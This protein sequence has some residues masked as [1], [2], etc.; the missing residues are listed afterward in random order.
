MKPVTIYS[1]EQVSALVTYSVWGMNLII[2]QRPREG[3]CTILLLLFCLNCKVKKT[4]KKK[5]KDINTH[6]IDMVSFADGCTFKRFHPVLYELVYL[7]NCTDYL[8][9]L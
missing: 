6:S 7:F 4:L 3:G 8:F 5:K 2:N 9:S 1:K